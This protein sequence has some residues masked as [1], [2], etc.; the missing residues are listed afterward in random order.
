VGDAGA[1]LACRETVTYPPPLNVTVAVTSQALRI[2]GAA[3]VAA[4]VSLGLTA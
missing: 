4:S 3:S 1:R 2:R